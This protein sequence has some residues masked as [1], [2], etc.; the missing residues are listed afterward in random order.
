MKVKMNMQ[1]VNDH[2]GVSGVSIKNRGYQVS[3]GTYVCI[4]RGRVFRMLIGQNMIGVA[5]FNCKIRK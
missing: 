5:V 2:M 1:D 4:E 3:N